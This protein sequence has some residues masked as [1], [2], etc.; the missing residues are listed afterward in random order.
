MINYRAWIP[1]IK[2][3]CYVRYFQDGAFLWRK[4]YVAGETKDN[5]SFIIHTYN[6]D[7]LHFVNKALGDVRFLP[8]LSGG[9][10][11]TLYKL[12]DVGHVNDGDLP[13]K[14]GMSE[15]ISLGLAFKEYDCVIPNGITKAGIYYFLEYYNK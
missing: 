15:L 10:V 2:T 9:A 1:E 12:F 11:D 3:E 8:I 4:C 7:G 6:D 13:S 14:S 5:L